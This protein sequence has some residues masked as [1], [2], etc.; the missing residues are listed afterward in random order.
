[1]KTAMTNPSTISVPLDYPR[2][3]SQGSARKPVARTATG[4]LPEVPRSV[5]ARGGYWD[6]PRLA[7]A[8][9]AVVADDDHAAIEATW[10]GLDSIGLAGLVFC[11]GSHA[12]NAAWI[13]GMMGG[14]AAA[15]P[16]RQMMAL[17]HLSRRPAASI[18]AVTAMRSDAFQLPAAPDAEAE[19]VIREAALC[20]A[21][22]IIWTLA[23]A[24]WPRL[25][26]AS[27]CRR[28]A[29]LLPGQ[30]IALTGD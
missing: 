14:G 4:R 19:P 28:V 10:K 9:T 16:G 26:V 23:G 11:L 22:V 6:A 12:R 1:M 24:G 25:Y 2:L 5:S 13:A 29:Q 8:L 3:A 15:S 27:Y 17:H 21:A 7:Y 20:L 30:R 18:L